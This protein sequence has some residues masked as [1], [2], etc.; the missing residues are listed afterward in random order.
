[1]S[2]VTT[3]P[4]SLKQ[5]DLSYNTITCWPSLPQIDTLDSFITCYSS[6]GTKLP[7]LL[8][9]HSGGS[10]RNIVLHS[11]CIHRRHLKLD[12][13]RTLI[14]TGNSLERIQLVN[15]HDEDDDPD[16][17]SFYFVGWDKTKASVLFFDLD[18]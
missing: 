12:N 8:G 6:D 2:H 18:G 9:R 16:F 4:N 14:I 5:I 15:D 13:L 1:M 3:Y 11:L 17:V 10:L 7:K